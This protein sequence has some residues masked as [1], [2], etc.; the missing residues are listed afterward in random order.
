MNEDS[1]FFSRF[2]AYIQWV[3][4]RSKTPTSR[5]EPNANVDP[6]NRRGEM[7]KAFSEFLDSDAGIPKDQFLHYELLG[8]MTNFAGGGGQAGG[9]GED[10]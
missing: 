2:K 6:N 10:N 7:L 1:P 3:K 5:G 8:K 9:R 4:E